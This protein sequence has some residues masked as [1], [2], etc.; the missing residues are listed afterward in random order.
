MNHIKDRFKKFWQTI[1]DASNFYNVQLFTTTHSPDGLIYFNE[2]LED[3]QNIAFRDKARIFT[4][5]QLPDES[6]KV[7][8]YSFKE[9]EFV[10][11]QGIEI[12][13]GKRVDTKPTI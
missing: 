8:K 5:R 12:R 7:Y 3:K 1:I 11:N 13:G 4:L 6:T 10:I 2:A 9:F